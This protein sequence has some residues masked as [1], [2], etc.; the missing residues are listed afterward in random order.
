M[1]VV[2]VFV[3][4]GVGGGIFVCAAILGALG[5]AV[6][7]DTMG[8][9]VRM[10]VNG[11]DTDALGGKGDELGI[12]VGVGAG[13]GVRVGV[14]VGMGIGLGSGVG[15]GVGVGSVSVIVGGIDNDFVCFRS[16][17]FGCFGGEA[18][19][20]LSFCCFLYFKSMLSISLTSKSSTSRR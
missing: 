18:G 15:S 4:I 2:G 3:G 14:G 12:G 13:V 10:G 11:D 6:G 1:G 19:M 9:W 20:C 16:G 17:C 7:E 5:V 8:E